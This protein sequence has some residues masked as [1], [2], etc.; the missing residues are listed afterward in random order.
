MLRM[1][2][3]IH[4]NDPHTTQAVIPHMLNDDVET[5]LKGVYLSLQAALAQRAYRLAPK[6]ESP[7]EIAKAALNMFTPSDDRITEGLLTDLVFNAQHTGM[8][9]GVTQL[10]PTIEGGMILVA[11]CLQDSRDFEV[12]ANDLVVDVATFLGL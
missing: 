8:D 12:A 4:K 3:A 11:Y 7:S 10:L 5:I 6:M 9:N 1:L 2:T